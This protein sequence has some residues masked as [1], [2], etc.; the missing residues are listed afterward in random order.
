MAPKLEDTLYTVYWNHSL[1]WCIYHLRHLLYFLHF[2]IR[3]YPLPCFH[4]QYVFSF[5]GYLSFLLT[6]CIQHPILLQV[7][8]LTD[9]TKLEWRLDSMVVAIPNLCHWIYLCWCSESMIPSSWQWV[10]LH[11]QNNL[12]LCTMAGCSQIATPSWTTTLRTKI[13]STDLVP[14][15]QLHTPPSSQVKGSNA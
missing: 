14:T 7:Q 2:T 10:V 1:H 13:Y 9:T 5:L 12:S 15:T 8:S 11:L 6:N 3:D 4:W